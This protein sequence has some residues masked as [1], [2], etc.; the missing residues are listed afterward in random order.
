MVNDMKKNYQKIL[1][2]GKVT[3]GIVAIGMIC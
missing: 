1:K 3:V 2:M